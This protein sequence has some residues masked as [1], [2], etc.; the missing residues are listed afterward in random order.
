M[1]SINI[2]SVIRGIRAMMFTKMTIDKFLDNPSKY[3]YLSGRE[4]KYTSGFVK[5]FD[6]NLHLLLNCV[7][8]NIFN[9]ENDGEEYIDY[10]Q[11]V[12]EYKEEAK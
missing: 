8:D 7:D 3:V 5:K 12:K 1:M 11:A 2:G 4:L 10:F 9:N 6:G